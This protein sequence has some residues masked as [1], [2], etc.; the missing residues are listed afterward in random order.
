MTFEERLA[1]AIKEAIIRDIDRY[2]TV[3]FPR[4]VVPKD[5]IEDVYKNIDMEKI[6]KYL[7]ENIEQLI[8]KKIVNS[9]MTDVASDVRQIIAT[10]PIR[11]DMQ[12]YLRQK[13][14]QAMQSVADAEPPVDTESES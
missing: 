10:K 1:D 14:E 2:H 8:A 6:K 12:Y 3:Q 11:E 7:A 4:F 5:V 13:M 9:I